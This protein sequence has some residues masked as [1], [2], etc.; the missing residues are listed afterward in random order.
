MCEAAVAVYCP[1]LSSD[2]CTRHI[3]V[4]TLPFTF[5]RFGLE[6]ARMPTQLRPGGHVRI[7]VANRTLNPI[8]LKKGTAVA[9][10]DHHFADRF[11]VHPS[12]IDPSSIETP[13]DELNVI[14]V[15][16]IAA[17]D[18]SIDVSGV[19]PDI[20]IGR[21]DL[22]LSQRRAL[23][24]LLREYSH[25]FA[26]DSAN[27]GHVDPAIFNFDIDTQGHTPVTCAPYRVSPAQ[28]AVIRDHVQKMQDAG[29]VVPS[30]S[31]WAS[32]V[33]LVPKP[34]GEIRFCVDFRALNKITKTEIFP[35]PRIDDTLDALAHA[36][37]FSTID[38]AAGYWQIPL[39]P[40]AREKTAFIC[41]EGLF[42]YTCM[43]FGLKNAPAAFQRFMTSVLGG[44]RWQCCLVYLDDVII[45]SRS[46]ERHL[47][48]L[49][50]VFDRLNEVGL[51]MKSKKC[52]FCCADVLYLG[53]LVSP[54]GIRPDPRKIAAVAEWP[55]PS[56]VTDVQ[57]FL[58]LASY[59]R[60]FI[61]RFASIAHPLY[62]LTRP[63]APFRWTAT[64]SS[65]FEALKTCLTTAPVLR[66]PDFSREFRFTLQTD[67]SDVGIGAVLHQSASDGRNH[68]IAYASRSL[69]PAE[70]KYTTQEKEALAIVWACDYFRP[71]LIGDPFT[72]ETDH[73]S[74]QWMMAA[75][76]GR[77]ARWALRIAEFEFS[78]THRKGSANANADALS[79]QPV[80]DRS[81]AVPS[82]DDHP[83]DVPTADDTFDRGDVLY[84]IGIDPADPTAPSVIVPVSVS[85]DPAAVGSDEPS[86]RLPPSDAQTSLRDRLRSEQLS[87]PFVSKLRSYIAGR[88]PTPPRLR[89]L[90]DACADVDGLLIHRYTDVRPSRLV[91]CTQVFVPQTLRNELVVL[92]HDHPLSGHLGSHRT[93]M[94]LRQNYYWPGMH[95]DVKRYVHSCALCQ[96]HKTKSPPNHPPL[97]YVHPGA[98]F[99]DV[100]VD[101]VGPHTETE[102]SNVYILVMQ[103]RFTKWPEAVPLPNKAAST[104][105]D[106]VFRH[107]ICRHGIPRNLHTDQGTEFNNVLLD[108]LSERLSMGRSSTTAY[109]PQANGQ[110]ER[111]NRTLIDSLRAY[112]D[113]NPATW[114][115]YLESVLF[116]YRTTPHA[117]LNETPFFLVYGRDP[118]LPWNVLGGSI[119]DIDRDLH[120]YKTQITGNLRHAHDIVRAQLR[121]LAESSKSFH[122]R[123][124]NAVDAVFPEGSHVLL[125]NPQG[126]HLS[127]DDPSR[128]LDRRWSGPFV[129]ETRRFDNVYR[130]RDPQ[131]GRTWSV[132]AGQLCPF[133]AESAPLPDAIRLSSA[134][135]SPLSLRRDVH[136]VA[137]DITRLPVSS[138][139]LSRRA[140]RLRA[141]AETVAADPEGDLRNY[142]VDHIVDHTPGKRNIKYRVRWE[143]YDASH[144]LWIPASSFTTHDILREYWANVRR[145]DPSVFV[146]RSFRP[147]P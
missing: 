67:A 115:R 72:V 71:Y 34:G 124:H 126:T 48:D 84:A 63:S 82:T 74:L 40:S 32:P 3:F 42:E 127:P 79:R 47:V 100:A 122:D 128:K 23:I 11:D 80:R 86:D 140:A 65:A 62:V 55:T 56:S 7:V 89:T 1:A 51:R 132:N 78:I 134:I 19:P 49:R 147:R 10:F 116:A 60:K 111:F 81:V 52:S 92:H 69:S 133:Y 98:A 4:S 131:S 144:D 50:S 101:L 45:Y 77:I 12:G 138:R 53:H 113:S 135:D 117:G 104:V 96:V 107:L 91:P 108:R 90:V 26:R 57:R 5:Q 28:R 14:T 8:V 18:P 73:Q 6:T 110:V 66:L 70:V 121:S 39:A 16:D 88:L 103:D 102:A 118:H 20:R 17:D 114:D 129:V 145:R 142:A 139:R 83:A 59:Y 64:E 44:L 136:T 46:F 35:L 68:V 75:K 143:G 31:P 13:E 120:V 123:Y 22:S 137:D 112:A 105:A 93:L 76:K 61:D 125:F 38:L 36:E 109:H 146:P 33:V 119:D 85:F 97:R 130:L 141:R 87:D 27:P 29:I 15:G 58:G 30:T 2:R 37:Y 43:P 95:V 99:A 94:R 24:D 41:H 25:L 21:S 106:A 54:D 9:A